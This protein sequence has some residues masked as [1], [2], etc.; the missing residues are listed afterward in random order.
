MIKQFWM[1]P[2]IF[3]TALPI[4]PNSTQLDPIGLGL[5]IVNAARVDAGLD[6]NPKH[7]PIVTGPFLIDEVS[8]TD[9]F[10]YVFG[11]S[12]GAQLKTAF[13]T[14]GYGFSDYQTVTKS[15]TVSGKVTHRVD[16][17]ALLL[18]LVILIRNGADATATVQYYYTFKGQVCPRM[19]G[20]TL[21]HANGAW[22]LTNSEVIGQC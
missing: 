5:A 3:L 4:Q 17:D 11:T 6:P 10:D 21:R 14:R 18:R 16:G 13:Q 1:L 12:T 15:D 9:N 20:L 8:F 19:L 22:N 7:G 2:A